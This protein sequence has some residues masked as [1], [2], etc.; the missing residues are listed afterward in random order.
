MT[1]IFSLTIWNNLSQALINN[2]W[3]AAILWL[4]LCVVQSSKKLSAKQE[5]RLAYGMQMG[6]FITFIFQLFHQKGIIDSNSWIEHRQNTSVKTNLISILYISLLTIVSLVRIIKISISNHSN[7]SYIV[8]AANQFSDFIIQQIEKFE[9]SRNVKLLLSKTLHSPYTKGILKPVIVLPIAILNQLPPDEVETLLLHELAHI[10]RWDYLFN[11]IQLIAETV[12]YFNPFT[13]LIGKEIRKNREI[14]CDNEVI[15]LTQNRKI[16]SQALVDLASLT[17]RNKDLSINQLAQGNKDS[18]FKIRLYN[19][20]NISKKESP[21]KWISNLTISLV[22]LVISSCFIL[23]KPTKKTTE[24]ALDNKVDKT[25]IIPA[26]EMEST[27]KEQ[28]SLASITSQSA[29][30]KEKPQAT[31]KPI[32]KHA[33]AKQNTKPKA[34][35]V[36][37]IQPVNSTTEKS[38]QNDQVQQQ[39]KQYAQL[40]A[41]N[42]DAKLY[43]INIAAG[44]SLNAYVQ[45]FANLLSARNQP[46]VAVS[47]RSE[48]RY[49]SASYDYNKKQMQATKSID[50][51]TPTATYTFTTDGHQTQLLVRKL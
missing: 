12:L 20:L 48:M 14:A 39:L 13:Y 26:V 47:N 34:S 46:V 8:E 38:Q 5:Y 15:E 18:E 51:E 44:D 11:I 4:L 36:E 43:Q 31:P 1:N 49:S 35:Q 17:V 33:I 9:I 32:V 22:A 50:L 2:I 42:E 3:I 25:Y 28:P 21:K 24:I 40:I 23:T 45:Q 7:K 27:P 37:D 30:M 6:L 41:Q 29:T 10:K 19:I 16:Y